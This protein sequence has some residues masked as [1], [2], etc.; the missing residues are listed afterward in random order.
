MGQPDIV[1]CRL[2][3]L[4]RSQESRPAAGGVSEGSGGMRSAIL[5]VSEDKCFPN[6]ARGGPDDAVALS[7]PRPY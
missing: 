3:L 1:G 6:D 2:R 7:L 5:I 4:E